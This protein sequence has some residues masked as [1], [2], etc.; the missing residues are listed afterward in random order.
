MGVD[1]VDG[2]AIRP[3]VGID[4]NEIEPIEKAMVG[5]NNLIAPYYQPSRVF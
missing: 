2:R 3:V 5:F 1:E 4:I